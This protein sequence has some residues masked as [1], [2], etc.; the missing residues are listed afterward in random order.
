MSLKYE[1]HRRTK[2][3]R[4]RGTET[5]GGATCFWRAETGGETE[6]ATTWGQ[7]SEAIGEMGGAT[8]C[9]KSTKATCGT[10][11]TA[12]IEGGVGTRR[13]GGCF[14]FLITLKPKVA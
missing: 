12:S 14:F 3:S 7:S 5:G 9:W 8:I 11:K 1:P 10:S 2:K 6:G 13:R 4:W